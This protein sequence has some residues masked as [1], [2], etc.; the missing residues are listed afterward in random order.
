VEVP[1][2]EV[3]A[4]G[5]LSVG[6]LSVGVDVSEKRGLDVVVLD[7]MRRLADPPRQRVSPDELLVYL[8]GLK[9]DAAV[10]AID[11][12]PALGLS[13]A[14]RPCELR[15]RARGVNVFSTPSDPA[16]FEKPFYN[17][18]RTGH[19]AFE[20]ARAAGFGLFAPE[21]GIRDSALEVY[22]HGTDVALRGGPPAPGVTKNPGRKRKWRTETLRMAGLRESH[23]LRS[24]DAVDAAL[25][26]FT[27]LCGLE[28]S[29]EA[30]GAPPFF[31]VIPR[32]LEAGPPAS[33][34]VE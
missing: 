16:R 17:W 19:E 9:P 3:P 1:A 7:S 29:F 33:F 15:L 32:A 18:M 24:L 34:P 22:P 11:S 6:V 25:A 26:A 31:I 21:K 14:S 30:V 12:P 8:D 2:V 20:A 10:V 27:G 23:R 4:V 13:G 5:V 28:G